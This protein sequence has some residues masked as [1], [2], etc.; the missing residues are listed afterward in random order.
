V[1]FFWTCLADSSHH[2]HR[3]QL[4]SAPAKKQ[5]QPLEAKRYLD[6]VES[7]TPP[8][9]AVLLSD[10]N[11]NEYYILGSKKCNK[12]LGVIKRSEI[13]RKAASMPTPAFLVNKDN[14]EILEWKSWADINQG[15]VPFYAVKFCKSEYIS[16][17]S[18]GL[19]SVTE[20]VLNQKKNMQTE[21]LS[22]NYDIIRQHLEIAEY[23]VKEEEKSERVEVIKHFSA[24][25]MNCK[26]AKHVVKLDHGKDKSRAFLKGRTDTT[27]EAIEASVS[28]KI[29]NVVNVGGKRTLK[30]DQSILNSETESKLDKALHSVSMEIEVPPNHSCVI[31]IKSKT[32]FARVPYSGQLIR[33]YR[34][35]EERTTS[36]TGIYDHQ[37]IAD[38][39]SFVYP[40]KPVPDPTRC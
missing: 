39:E 22:V 27:G 35:G 8:K 2:I 12:A 28:G 33:Q 6:L 1:C 18:T 40:C 24:Q 29:L 31:E 14:F 10:D 38:L 5:G 4:P 13:S 30:S 36:I 16:K 11:N 17:D 32:F 20:K 19:H 9:D 34:N 23:V 21:V 3:R 15:Q 25:N 37:E 7:K 26:P